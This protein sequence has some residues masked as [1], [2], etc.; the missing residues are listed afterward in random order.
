MPETD[1]V[2]LV[3][4][5]PQADSIKA[6][7]GSVRYSDD[8]AGEVETLAT[9]HGATESLICAANGALVNITAG[10]AGTSLGTGFANDRWQHCEFAGRIIFCNG[11][12]T[13]RDWDGTTLTTTAVYGHTIIANGDMTT[14]SI[15]AKGTGWTIA[16]GVA[17]SDGS[18]AAASLLSQTPIYAIENT[19]T[20]VV[21]FTISGYSAGNLRAVVGTANGTN[22]AANGTFV[23]TITAGAGALFALEADADFVGSVDSVSIAKT[24]E[25]FITCT[26][27]QGRVFYIEKDSQ[28]FHYAAAGS[29]AGYTSRFDLSTI[30]G[31]GADLMFMA[32]WSRDSGSGMDD[33]GA[34][35]FADGTVVVYQGDDP[36]VANSWSMVGTF[37]IGAPLSRRASTKIGGDVVILTV[38]G[39][40]PLSV[41]LVE[42]QYSEQGAFSFKI[43]RAAKEAAQTWGSQYG[44][45][46]IHFPEGSMYV[47]NV[48]ISASQAIQHVRNTITG[49]W[50]KFTGWNAVQFA[51]LDGNLYFG[52]PDGYVYKVAG[53]SDNG[54]Y[55]PFEAIQAYQYFGNPHV[56]KQITLAQAFTNYAFPR[57]IDYKFFEDYNEKSLSDI[58]DPPEAAVSEWDIGEWDIA[59]W[60]AGSPGVRKARRNVQGNGFA[61]ALVLRFKSRAQSVT[62]W[63]T[64]LMFNNTG[65]I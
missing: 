52:S 39:Y 29:Y 46:S 42:G 43:D 15:W 55:I 49:M 8:L 40:V 62:W 11:A 34:F 20:Y 50:C 22:R 2:E 56:Q 32:S 53:A 5:I 26:V 7:P 47:V 59:V 17:S 27:H 65:V 6:R 14:D 4:L 51:I 31:T 41:A 60:N 3:N 19:Q 37:K 10:G 35:L 54:A 48:P 9:Y 13:V 24:S 64:Q 36:S 16:A 33:L 1:A 57:Y 58:P 45:S 44:W 63:A 23:Q 25:D 38:D 21:T 30:A 28:A 12:N 18:Q 61:L